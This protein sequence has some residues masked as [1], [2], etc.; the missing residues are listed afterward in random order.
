MH[1]QVGIKAWKFTLVMNRNIDIEGEH[2]D[3]YMLEHYGS[4]NP[5]LSGANLLNPT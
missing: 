4:I 3:D 2:I 1:S 5:N